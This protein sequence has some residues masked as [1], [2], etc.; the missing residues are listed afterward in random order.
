[1]PV[2]A[3]MYLGGGGNTAEQQEQCEREAA[4]LGWAVVTVVRDPAGVRAGW[5]QLWAMHQQGDIDRILMAHRHVLALPT[6]IHVVAESD[7][8]DRDRRPRRLR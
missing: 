2:R 7:P 6:F 4:R 8:A 1:M 5:L 3:G